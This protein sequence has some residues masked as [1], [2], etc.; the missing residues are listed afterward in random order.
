MLYLQ[1]ATVQYYTIT[2][3]NILG[4]RLSELT[5]LISAETQKENIFL[6]AGLVLTGGGS[7]TIEITSYMNKI[8]PYCTKK[9]K[10]SIPIE[11]CKHLNLTDASLSYSTQLATV[12][13]LLYLENIH[14]SQLKSP[15]KTW[16]INKYF[17]ELALWFKE[18][19]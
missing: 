1:L 2:V 9:T 7:E 14:Q 17:R 4:P 11:L 16:R 12:L 5:N 19:S 13:G 6:G 10:P 3:Y 8:L 18:L 15:N